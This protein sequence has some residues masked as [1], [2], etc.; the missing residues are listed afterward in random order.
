VL[1]VTWQRVSVDI[2]EV[3]LKPIKDSY[4]SG[5]IRLRPEFKKSKQYDLATSMAELIDNQQG[6]FKDYLALLYCR[7]WLLVRMSD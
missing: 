1:Y 3:Q 5:Q 2:S 7:C 6:I 4:K